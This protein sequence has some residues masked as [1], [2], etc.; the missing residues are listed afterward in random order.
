MSPSEFYR[1]AKIQYFPPNINPI[2]QNIVFLPPQ[3]PLNDGNRKN[4]AAS[5]A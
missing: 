1:I 2:P 4:P 3:N 5:M